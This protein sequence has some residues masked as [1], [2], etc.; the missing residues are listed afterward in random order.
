MDPLPATLGSFKDF[1]VQGDEK[2]SEKVV[3]Y[4]TGVEFNRRGNSFQA[5]EYWQR[6][7]PDPLRPSCIL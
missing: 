5:D 7:D 3:W 4:I 6:K 2:L 1:G